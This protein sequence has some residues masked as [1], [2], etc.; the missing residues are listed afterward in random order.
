MKL[1]NVE[2]SRIPWFV[3]APAFL[4]VTAILGLTT[5]Y[6]GG[7]YFKRTFLEE[8]NP[9]VTDSAPPSPTAD[10]PAPTMMAVMT[11]PTASP[12]ASPTPSGPVTISS[13]EFRNGAPGHIGSGTASLGR[14]AAG[15]P[16]LVLADFSVTNGPD[17]HVILGDS[18]EGGGD[19]LDLGPL[20]ATDGTFSYEVPAAADLESFRSV[21][22]FCKSFPTIFAVATLG[23]S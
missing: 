21:T 19:G 7:D 2:F 11:T 5:N 20:K 12:S 14:D 8:A 17:L 10:S 16:V 23:G 4:V 9:L 3:A 18:E 1:V 22:I 15:N 6:F 13:G